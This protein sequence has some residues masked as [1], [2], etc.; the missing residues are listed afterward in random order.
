M[1]DSRTPRR[2]GFAFV[3][4][5]AVESLW[6]LGVDLPYAETVRLMLS[7]LRDNFHIALTVYQDRK[8]WFV[9]CIIPP[10]TQTPDR[11]QTSVSEPISFWGVLAVP[12]DQKT[13]EKFS[14]V[15]LT[16]LHPNSMIVRRLWHNEDPGDLI[17]NYIRFKGE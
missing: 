5:H 8:K 15:V 9:P 16:S 1:P 12:S 10:I 11:P 4:S 3:T 6:D 14:Y 7:K 17:E 2:N 13:I